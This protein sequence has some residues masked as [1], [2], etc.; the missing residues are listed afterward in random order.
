MS[1]NNPF[2]LADVL[3]Q[4]VTRSGYTPG[5]LAKLSGIP[6]PTI[7]NW[8][9]GR[10]RKPRGVNDLLRLTAVLH[11]QESEASNLLQS[12][13]HPAIPELRQSAIQTGN[14]KQVKLLAQWA[15][16]PQPQ[17][18]QAPFQA[19]ADLP[20]FVGRETELTT[21]KQALMQ[22]EHSTLYSLHGMGGIGKTALAVHIAYQIRFHFPDGVLW[23]NVDMSDVMSVLGTFASAYGLDVSP[24]GDV[25]S[26]SR[27]VRELLASKRALIVL[28]NVNSSEQITPLL[29]PT[30]TCAVLVTTRRH[31]LSTLRGATRF[32]MAPFD[33]EKAESLALFARVLGDERVGM[34]RPLFTELAN[35][36]GHLPLA[37][38]IAA[39]RLAY[40]PGWSTADF[41][42]RVRQERRRLAELTYEDQSVRLS[43]NIS[44]HALPSEIQQFFA[45]LGCFVGQ[46]FNDEATA[47]I[48]N[49]SI[50]D[51]QDYLRQLFAMSLVQQAQASV[52][53]K[54]RYQLHLLLQDFAR[55]QMQDTAVSTRYVH[56][57]VGFV[58]ENGRILEN[59][60]PVFQDVLAALQHAA[61]HQM[62]KEFVQGVNGIY[63]FLEARGLYD[64]AA[65]LLDQMQ[66]KLSQLNDAQANMMAL[67]NQGRL[68][69]HRGEYIEAETK[70]EAAL[71]L[72]RTLTNHEQLSHL[73][74]ALG[75]LA[76]RRGDY[77]LA[78]AYYKEGLT[79]TRE[80][81][82]GSP[83]SNFL[84]GLGVQAYM[85][86]NYARAEMFYEEGLALLEM[87]DADAQDPR[88][89]GSKLLGLGLL[90]HEQGDY[91]QAQDYFSQSLTLARQVGHLERVIV[92][93]RNLANLYWDQQLAEQAA[94]YN[95]SA[96]KMAREIGHRWQV[97]RSL[98][99]RGEI[100]VASDD[101]IAAED[102]FREL[103]DL[104][105]M[106]QSQELI[107]VALYGL[108]RV[109]AVNGN[110]P[111]AIRYAQESLDTFIAIGHHQVNDVQNWL[112]SLTN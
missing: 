26:R 23:A 41:L 48:A 57:F 88:V 24:Y 86:G 80:I 67:H 9:E 100:Q 34:E 104:A 60:D 10:V 58:G 82:Y 21:L 97:A 56:Y 36:L 47:A 71:T 33:A 16:Q 32:T 42:Q 77:V 111:S 64:V 6:K 2:Q 90:A 49:V 72:A 106:M 66:N 68:A 78:N 14:N 74:R 15:E 4:Y 25:S 7:V 102:S 20:Y 18:K 73:L 39:G 50:E 13:G 83:V 1:G 38:D 27:V 85:Q 103:Y 12:A 29:P 5:Q 30:G 112:N 40:E 61:D 46:S 54:P 81:G 70:Y 91:E 45:A 31:D 17:A 98:G 44:Y 99:E 19:M 75:V 108:G 55:K 53:G 63:Y 96:L 94:S 79:L 84:R 87:R 11:L 107:G 95:E 93:L 76:A 109:T 110:I 105:R 28:D 51:A 92:L 59:I 35:L 52:N 101:T 65:G 8:L 3:G 62:H 43:F 89:T 69:Q 37:V 22:A